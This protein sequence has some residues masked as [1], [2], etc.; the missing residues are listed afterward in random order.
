MTARSQDARSAH[1]ALALLRATLVAVILLTEPLVDGRQLGH[2]A[3]RVM[4]S[5]AALYAV[6]GIAFALRGP[7]GR[8]AQ[9]ISRIQ[10]GLDMLLLAGLTYASGGAFS[11]A[12][13]AFFVVP[14]AGAF[15]ERQRETAGWSLLAVAVFTFVAVI[16]G[17]PPRD[18][19]V[20]WQRLTINQDLYL[21]WTGAAAT[22]LAVALRRRS[23]HTAELAA[24][25][26][27]LV[28]HAIESVER[29]RT[30]L[31]GALH[32]S[33]VQNLIAA[34]LDLRRA[35]RN[36]DPDSFRRLHEA[37]D[38]TIAE[39]R[40]EIFRL[41]PHVLDH[42]GLSAAFEQVA[43]HHAEGGDV[44]ITV[45]VDAEGDGEQRQVLFALGRELLTN[46]AKHA[47]A[48][49][50]LLSLRREGHQILLE[51]QDDGCGIENGRMRQALLDG[52]VGL[53]SVRERVAVLDGTLDVISAPGSG[54]AVRIALPLPDPGDAPPTGV[55]HR[56]TSLDTHLVS[57]V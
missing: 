9:T 1:I 51:V 3:F 8:T 26:Q 20:T 14:L 37:I 21:A 12:R 22:L 40:E 23:A 48:S 2:Y 25:R 31:A 43:R 44:T 41:H 53:A 45:A 54:T 7:Q 49:Q 34:R 55:S 36:G 46:A 35:E 5:V 15:S 57:P 6:I 4:L 13:K 19:T 10:P 24:S 16:A 56:V 42:V 17:G 33:P 18:S 11:D 32:D 27:Q 50:I 30:R 29:E 39:L 28:T 38:A 52:H 47:Q